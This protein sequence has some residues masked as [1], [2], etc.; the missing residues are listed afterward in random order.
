M[1]EAKKI[2]ELTSRSASSITGNE[3]IPVSD[4]GANYRISVDGLAEYIGKDVFAFDLVTT[5]TESDTVVN[6]TPSSGATGD[7]AYVSNVDSGIFA[8]RVENSGNYVFY[9]Q[10]TSADC[11]TGAP[12]VGK[13]YLCGN[14]ATIWRVVSNAFTQITQ[15]G[16]PYPV[17]DSTNPIESGGVYDLAKKVAQNTA[18]ISEYTAVAA[19]QTKTGYFIKNNG[20]ESANVNFQYQKFLVV[21]GCEYAFSAQFNTGNAHI[22]FW[23]DNSD[24]LIYYEDYMMGV[25]VTFTDEKMLAPFNASYCLMNEH[26]NFLSSYKFNAFSP[27]IK[28]RELKAYVEQLQG[29]VIDIPDIREAVTQ[30]TTTQLAIDSTIPNGFYLSTGEWSSNSNYH[31]DKYAVTGGGLYAFSGY[32]PA[33]TDIYFG[34]WLDANGLFIDI[35]PYR[36]SRDSSVTYVNQNITAPSGAAYLFL[37]VRNANAS[38]FNAL[39]TASSYIYSSELKQDIDALSGSIGKRMK[40]FFIGTDTY[41]RT[42]YDSTHDLIY[43][44]VEKPNGNIA[45]SATYY[46]LK[47]STDNEILSNVIHN[48]SDSTAPMRQVPQYWHL[49]A[50]HGIPIPMATITSNPLTSADVGAWWKDQNNRQYQIGKV[51]GNSVYLIPRVVPSGTD[52]IV[53]RDWRDSTKDSYP[54]GLTWVS[55]GVYTSDL[56]IA[57]CSQYQVRPMQ[58]PSDKRFLC[59]GHEVAPTGA[60]YCDEFVITET[61]AC[62]DPTTMTAY[63]PTP[64][65]SQ[66]AFTITNSFIV[67]GLSI[68]FNQLVSC[69]NPF[70]FN[71]YG[72]N[73]AQH[74]IDIGGNTAYCM[75]PK[76]KKNNSNSIPMRKFFRASTS[77]SSVTIYRSTSDLYD[78]D[79]MPERQLSMLKDSNGVP[80]FGFASGLSLVRGVTRDE[81]RNTYIAQSTGDAGYCLNFSPVNQ[82]KFYVVAINGNNTAKFTNKL[83]QP[84]FCEEFS[85]YYT[86]YHPT[87][88]VN[89][90]W[91]YDGTDTV[92]YVHSESNVGRVI[93]DVNLAGCEGKTLEVVERSADTSVLYSAAVVNG[94]VC[95]GL[96][97]TEA[98]YIVLKVK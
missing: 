46:G 17:K 85:S 43:Q 15:E 34:G 9:K 33:D 44:F 48:W 40:V 6:D 20:T 1:A 88:D 63:F 92:F 73:Q 49:F 16:E 12:I 72:Q 77:D 3:Q 79:K 69:D 95:V 58:I 78:V 38:S 62:L 50:Q 18:D 13:T 25:G 96:S 74:L 76:T 45:P 65:S 68:G 66:N 53:T 83:I 97:G 55:G 31:V 37:N 67:K 27:S 82:N 61:L 87:S 42:S 71:Y 35:L 56:T 14:P 39:S 10:F 29:A 59:N 28:S 94:K 41:I 2:S 60:Y 52:G 19:V 8:F 75:I 4:S 47:S 70:Q 36:G 11:H 89:A 54:T 98:N 57:S 90:Y 80:F 21:G 24:N 22:I 93:V 5:K 91:Y 32:Y 84:D 30:H 26:V 51:D 81:V 86:Y 23:F 7:I 64:T